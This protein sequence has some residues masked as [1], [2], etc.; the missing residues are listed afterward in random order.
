MQRCLALASLVVAFAL[1]LAPVPHACAQLRGELELEGLDCVDAASLESR[2][3]AYLRRPAFT[4]PPDIRLELNITESSGGL[5]ADLV[6]RRLD[7]QERGRRVLLAPRE[8]CAT[9]GRE[10]ALV[11]ALL[12][13]S[14]RQEVVLTVPATESE[15]VAE[16]PRPP[17]PGSAR[18]SHRE[19]PPLR[20]ATSGQI[21]GIAS[22]DLLPGVVAGVRGAVA[23]DVG[24]APR[25][26]G[27]LE[28]HATAASGD[29]PRLDGLLAVAGALVCPALFARSAVRLDL[30]AGLSAGVFVAQ[31]RGLDSTPSILRGYTDLRLEL[32]IS[33][34]L[35][36][37]IGLRFELGAMAPIT[38]QR[39]VYGTAEGL[40]VLHESAPLVPRASLGLIFGGP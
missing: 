28:L 19:R 32:G 6:M 20:V 15:P 33:W 14:E 21:L 23:L 30:C 40:A 17:P 24:H 36:R 35:T 5:R 2:V 38:R 13:E 3:A 22:V 7:G 8:R 18:R 39:F 1:G 9:L 11:V 12:L 25:L 16:P 34:A 37:S 4:P 27:L 31:P 10:I 26:T 29:G